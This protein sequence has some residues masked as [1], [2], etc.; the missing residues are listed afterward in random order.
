M[1]MGEIVPLDIFYRGSRNYIQGSLIISRVV[2]FLSAKAGHALV[3]ERARFRRILNGNLGLAVNGEV[4]DH[5][6]LGDVTIRD[7]HES[8]T[9]Y[10]LC[11]D[12]ART[13]PVPRHPDDASRISHYQALGPLAACALFRP[14]LNFDDVIA[15]A[16]ETVKRCVTESF[17]GCS[18]VWFTALQRSELASDLGHQRPGGTIHIGNGLAKH[19]GERIMTRHD[20]RFDFEDAGERRFEM[21]FTCRL[22]RA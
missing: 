14:F 20:V 9:T 3:V 2:D 4:P 22:S 12:E 7:P 5:L 1:T 6:F 18:D 21:L 16:V 13:R 8:R 15:T 10:I 17:P 11:E 19:E